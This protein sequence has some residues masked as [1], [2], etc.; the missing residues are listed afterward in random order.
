M[1]YPLPAPVKIQ[2]TEINYSYIPEY[3][4][5]NIIPVVKPKPPKKLS[6][7]DGIEDFG[8]DEL[9]PFQPET[10]N[11]S[12]AKR[13]L[14]YFCLAIVFLFVLPYFLRVVRKK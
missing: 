10:T 2:G 9:T 12:K 6:L 8:E 7:F 3:S 1:K 14:L 4:K 11:K 13:Y 5:F